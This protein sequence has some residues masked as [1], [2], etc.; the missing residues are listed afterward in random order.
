MHLD[1]LH[2]PVDHLMNTPVESVLSMATLF[3][4]RP[5][6]RLFSLRLTCVHSQ[7]GFSFSVN[8]EIQRS[9]VLLPPSPRSSYEV[10]STSFTLLKIPYRKQW[11]NCECCKPEWRNPFRC[12]KFRHHSKG[13][14]GRSF[15]SNC[16]TYQTNA[17][18]GTIVGI[19]R[20]PIMCQ[21]D[22][23]ISDALSTLYAN[24]VRFHSL[25][26]PLFLT[27]VASHSS[28]SNSNWPE[29]WA[30]VICGHN[31]SGFDRSAYNRVWTLSPLTSSHVPLSNFLLKAQM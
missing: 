8:R 4:L 16:L 22:T 7:W 17:E 3:F 1:R 15:P 19:L 25:L 23:P 29:I 18:L 30:R 10:H 26:Y 27:V 12:E 6:P 5:H 9:E 31:D 2:F 14:G 24:R 21:I 13:K 28:I 11:G 20:S